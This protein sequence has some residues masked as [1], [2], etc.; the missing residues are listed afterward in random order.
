[1]RSSTGMAT[2][3]PA[4][5][6]IDGVANFR[7]IGGYS[8]GNGNIVRRNFI[9][10]SADMKKLT[11][12]G[13]AALEKL[14]I[15]DIF[16][17][18]STVEVQ[19]AKLGNGEAVLDVWKQSARGPSVHLVPIFDEQDYSPESLAKRFKDYASEGTEVSAAVVCML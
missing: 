12:A 1:M 3:D 8:A 2:L 5:K 19:K 16:D 14:S 7:D 6:N 11:P 13:R 9:Y 17:L 15:R 18:R 10:R 4:F